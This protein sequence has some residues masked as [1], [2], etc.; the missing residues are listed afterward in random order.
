M[1]TIAALRQ[2]LVRPDGV[3]RIG[4]ALWMMVGEPVQPARLLWARGLLGPKGDELLWDALLARRCLVG[5][6]LV[7][8]PLA[9][10]KLLCGLW[11]DAEDETADLSLVWTLP[12]ALR[13]AGIEANG[14]A[15]EAVR[16]ING[17]NKRV[18]IVSPYL[19]PRGMGQ[20]HGALLEVLARTVDVTLIAHDI[21]DAASLASAALEP[22]RRESRGFPGRLNV[23]TAPTSSDVLL[24]LK[25]VVVDGLAA[26]VGSAN[27]TGQ[28][29]GK[30]LETGALMGADAAGE[31]EAVVHAV[32]EQGF[33][34]LQYKT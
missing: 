11:Q 9:L 7:L 33:A 20:L 6:Q 34:A 17:A 26:V 31:I 19:E 24:H 3:R 18:L 21:G 30:N 12:S 15:R 27:V 5:E 1:S 4:Q 32:I 16:L 2:Q 8:E 10:S 23:Y 22:L 28:G 14:Y 13:I 29:F 25:V